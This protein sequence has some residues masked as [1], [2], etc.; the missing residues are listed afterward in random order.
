MLSITPIP[1][2][3][4]FMQLIQVQSK[5][6]SSNILSLHLSHSTHAVLPAAHRVEVCKVSS[7]KAVSIR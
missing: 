3:V 6:I 1:L 7:G 4:A 2:S 5:A